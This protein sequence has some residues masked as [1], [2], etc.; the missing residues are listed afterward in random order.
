MLYA[1]AS[2]AQGGGIPADL[3]RLRKFNTWGV[4]QYSEQHSTIRALELP[5]YRKLT[6]YPQIGDAVNLSGDKIRRR[7]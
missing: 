5:D 4:D 6:R 2:W 7:E 3:E 1:D